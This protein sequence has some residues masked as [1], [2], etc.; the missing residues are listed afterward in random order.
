MISG[1]L[2]ALEIGAAVADTSAGG[3][4]CRVDRTRPQSQGHRAPPASAAIEGN[5]EE[6]GPP[7]GEVVRR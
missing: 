7:V 6:E 4:E 5:L 1:E 2:G 3:A